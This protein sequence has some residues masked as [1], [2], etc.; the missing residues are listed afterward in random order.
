MAVLHSIQV[1]VST[2]RG[3][4][5]SQDPMEQQWRSAFV[6]EYVEGPVVVGQT[7]IEGD[8]QADLQV[9]GGPDKAMLAYALSH[10]P[11]WRA[12]LGI[13]TIG[14]GGFGENLTISQLTE[15]DV[16]IGDIWA[17]GDVRVQVS[18]P[19]QPCW[20]LARRWQFKQLPKL[21]VQSGRS[22][23]YL[24]VL[25]T[26]LIES[27]MS[28]VLKTRNH[29]EWTIERCNHA[30][31]DRTF[32]REEALQLVEIADLAASWKEDLLERISVR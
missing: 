10:Y 13:E 28:L 5:G 4:A 18:Q 25:N 1:G 6:K 29:S 21:V 16:C 2:T 31:Y 27:Q 15:A 12:E 30:L 8:A 3:E 26:G 32:P 22:G 9:H 23:W 20:K 19:R 14:P 11:K 7:N 24:R 17:I